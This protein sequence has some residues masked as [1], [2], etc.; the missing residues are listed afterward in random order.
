MALALAAW[1]SGA[2]APGADTACSATGRSGEA[3]APGVLGPDGRGRLDSASAEADRPFRGLPCSV[4]RA[5]DWLRAAR[6]DTEALEIDW[7]LTEVT[8]GLIEVSCA[9]SASPTECCECVF[10]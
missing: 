7:G 9:P 10:G 1:P 6:F 5:D 4:G 2:G 3:D 8:A